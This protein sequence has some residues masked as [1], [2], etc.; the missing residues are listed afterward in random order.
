MTFEKN[1]IAALKEIDTPKKSKWYCDRS[2]CDGE[3][4]DEWHWCDHPNGEH[5][6]HTWTCRHARAAQHPPPGEW[7]VWMFLGGR[8]TGKTRAG[9][10]W[11]AHQVRL[12]P[13]RWWL[14]IGKSI[15]QTREVSLEGPSG[16]LMA[17]GLT[18]TSKEYN[19]TTGEIRLKNGT[20]ILS[21]SAEEPNTLKGPNFAGAWADEISS[22]HYADETW[23]ELELA[24]RIEVGGEVPKKVVTTTPAGTKLVRRLVNDPET[25]VTRGISADNI[26]NVSKRAYD[27][28]LRQWQGTRKG[29]QELFGELI[30]DVEGAL[31]NDDLI[32]STTI[33][34]VPGMKPALFASKE[35]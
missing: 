31:W 1:L 3:P 26:K 8:M 24:T 20:V 14:V 21:R 22:W 27:E 25:K 34:N 19:R 7:A 18:P 13:E 28:L 10:E 2:N 15:K 6:S 12:H 11:L 23:A 9:A 35:D 16:L 17:L 30:E 29:R 5:E 33:L 4:H 32:E